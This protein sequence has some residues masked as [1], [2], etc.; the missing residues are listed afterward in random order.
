MATCLLIQNVSA[1]L[2]SFHPTFS[3]LNINDSRAMSRVIVI[4][5]VCMF[6]SRR[7]FHTCRLSIID[8]LH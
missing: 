5:D 3:Y 2:L 8:D 4:F 7:R 1:D 6:L